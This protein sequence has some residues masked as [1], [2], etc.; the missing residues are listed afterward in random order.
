MKHGATTGHAPHDR[1]LADSAV[2]SFVAIERL[3]P[4]GA[5]VGT[6]DRHD[7]ILL[8]AALQ[9]LLRESPDTIDVRRCQARAGSFRMNLGEE[10][11]LRAVH[12]TDTGKEALI[13]E[14]RADR[15]A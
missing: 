10:K 5:T 13:E 4:L 9:Q 12:V 11:D 8:G 7:A 14:Q 2:A 6:L 1:R 15:T 3:R